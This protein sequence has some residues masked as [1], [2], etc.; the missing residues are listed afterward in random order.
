MTQVFDC[1]V[2]GG[3]FAGL[4][5]ADQLCRQ[6]LKTLLLEA[7][8]RMGGRVMTSQLDDST[9]IDLGGQWIGPGHDRMYALCQ[10]FGKKTYPMHTKGRHL[11]SFGG[12]VRA[13]RGHIPY[14]LPFLALGQMGLV[15]AKLEILARRIPVEDPW[16][17]PDARSLDQRTFG[18]WLRG[19]ATHPEAAHVAQIAFESVFAAHPDEV[20]LLHA[21]F[22]MRASGGFDYLTRSRRGAQQ[23]R[24]HGG[25]QQLAECLGAEVDKHGLRQCESVVTHVQTHNEHVTVRSSSGEYVGKR[26]IIALPPKP[27][28]EICF[29]P[30]LSSNRLSLLEGM[31]MGSVIKCLASY[32]TPFWRDDGLSGSAI[33]T[34]PP[35][36]VT[37][38]ASPASG[39]PGLLL[40]FIE[41]AH[42]REFASASSED[43][44]E[45]VLHAFGHLFGE[46]A[47]NP[48][49]YMDHVWAHEAFSGGCYSAI[50][51][52]GLWTA[53]GQ[54]IRRP[55]GRVHWAGTETATAYT[56]YIEGAVRSGERAAQEVIE[57]HV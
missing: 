2:V 18:D 20:S 9:P 48:R 36:N 19:Q 55:D 41:G 54:T 8:D 25:V 28:Q 40:G 12:Q 53:V 13:Y 32:D 4:T 1:I 17:A 52:P 15:L 3:G 34:T 22:Y 57:H 49:Q 29:E 47:L 45:R 23:D 35:V 16:S 33:C 30:A 11:H 38:D 56:G 46:R 24:I 43:R 44:R 27:T 14:R 5:A 6:G 10:R 51:P 26:I 37:F 50:F 39:T 31:A 7:R 42:A 21:L